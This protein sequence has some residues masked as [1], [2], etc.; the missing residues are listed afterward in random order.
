MPKIVISHDVTDVETWLTFNT[1][2]AAAI[3]GMGGREVVDHVAHDGTNNVA[4]SA[5]VDDVESLLA[6]IASPPADLAEAMARHGVI[7]PLTVYVEK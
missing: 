2:R 1:E 6:A 5:E 4:V 7:P 3:A